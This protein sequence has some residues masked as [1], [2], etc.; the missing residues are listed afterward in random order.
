V[1]EL[2]IDRE[3]A[4]TR[5]HTVVSVTR[6]EYAAMLDALAELAEITETL[7]FVTQDGPY[8]DGMLVRDLQVAR[9]A[10]ARVRHLIGDG[11]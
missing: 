5:H 7:D 11:R 4:R 6:S 8:I 3:R 10:L 1:S 9:A 2:W